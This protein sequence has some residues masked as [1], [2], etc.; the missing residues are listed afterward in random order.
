MPAA[1]NMIYCATTAIWSSGSTGV[2]HVFYRLFSI[3]LGDREDA[4]TN[5]CRRPAWRLRPAA[6]FLDPAHRHNVLRAISPDAPKTCSGGAGEAYR[7]YS[8]TRYP[9]SLEIARSQCP[10]RV[11]ADMASRLGSVGFTPESGQTA[12]VS[13]CPLCAKSGPRHCSKRRTPV[14]TS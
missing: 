7:S 14:A 4:A 8:L 11:T 6:R 3:S 12:E 2:R 1:T 10:L 5:V 9:A 13:G